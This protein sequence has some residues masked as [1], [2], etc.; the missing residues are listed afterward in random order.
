MS[1]KSYAT[2]DIKI[3][4]DGDP[5][6]FVAVIS[7]DRLDRDGEKLAAGCF[8]PLPEMV[9]CHVDHVFS[10][11]S[12][13]GS[14]RPYYEAGE[15]RM[16]GT[17]ASTAKAQEVRELVRS[18]HLNAM[19]VGF[20]RQKTEKQKGVPVVTRGT[21]LEASFVTIGSQPDA[22]IL[23]VRALGDE[24]EN[25][26]LRAWAMALA[27]RDQELVPQRASLEAD[28][29]DLPRPYDPARM[30]RNIGEAR[31]EQARE[32]GRQALLLDQRFSPPPRCTG[33]GYPRDCAQSFGP[34]PDSWEEDIDGPR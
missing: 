6:T 5:G 12:L 22:R 17:F 34:P 26:R 4:D 21:L 13:V 24:D 8:K 11:D 32:Q 30:Q 29:N 19:S 23:A 18:R 3:V 14:G 28:R 10:V 16:K 9:P 2:L 27:Y 1:N 7:T 31:Q 20:I 15:L 25:V 33:H